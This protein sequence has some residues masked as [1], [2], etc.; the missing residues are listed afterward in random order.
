[1]AG[2][3]EVPVSFPSRMKE[4]MLYYVYFF[5]KRV[6]E[7]VQVDILGSKK[8]PWIIENIV[9]TFVED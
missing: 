4:P 2:A 1:M 8:L 5:F 7:L 3:G 9:S 6:K